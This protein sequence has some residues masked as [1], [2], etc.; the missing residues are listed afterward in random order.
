MKLVTGNIS[1][2][3][4]CKRG[5]AVGFFYRLILPIMILAMLLLSSCSPRQE[6][7]LPPPPMKVGVVA[8]E[9][10]DIEQP[11]RVSGALRYIANTTVSAEVSAQV[12][13]IEVEDGQPVKAGDIL[14]VFDDTKI[15]ETA[16]QALGNLQKNEAVL[17]FNKLEWE[18]NEG[19]FKSGSISQTQHD[20]KFS[21]YQNA[22]AQVKADR[23]VL[24]KAL[25]DLNKTKVKSPITGLLSHRYI[26]RGDWIQEGGRLFQISDYRRIYLEAPLS[27]VDVAKLNIKKV[28]TEGIDASVSVDPYPGKIFDG[29]LTYIQPV[30]GEE[31]LFQIRIYLDNPEML[32]LQGMFARG[33]IVI[34]TVAGVLRIPLEALMDQVRNNE[35]NTV[36][37]VDDGKKAK[38]T[39]IK[40]GA[41]NQRYAEVVEGL[42][43]GDMVVAKGKEVL[44]TGQPLDV[45]ILQVTQNE[46]RP[47]PSKASK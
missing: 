35:Y 42:Q 33:R 16:N 37:V 12:Q 6:N 8:V 23:A 26:E 28:L 31:R 14:L 32:L 22:L 36:F 47:L 5:H 34:K 21:A 15:K 45:T 18:K 30:A 13:S 4:P 1:V 9:K 25:E 27:D 40:I 41:N 7:K 44:S 46:T 10:G 20:Q 43:T 38:L 17:T 29:R 3:L 11:L 24:A 19:L 39:R 2:I